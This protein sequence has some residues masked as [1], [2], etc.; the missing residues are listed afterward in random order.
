MTVDERVHGMRLRVI[1]RAQVHGSVRGES[2]GVG[3]AGGE[4]LQEVPLN[5]RRIV[6]GAVLG[7]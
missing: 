5:P 3:R 6:K 7:N 1:E 2:E 4:A